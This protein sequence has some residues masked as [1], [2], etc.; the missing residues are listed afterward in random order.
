M[1]AEAS[2]APFGIIVST[3]TLKKNS[4]DVSSSPSKDGIDP[5]KQPP[6]TSSISLSF[7]TP[8]SCVVVCALENDRLFSLTL[9]FPVVV[10]VAASH[11]LTTRNVCCEK[12]STLTSIIDETKNRNNTSVAMVLIAVRDPEAMR[13]ENGNGLVLLG[14]LIFMVIAGRK[15]APLIKF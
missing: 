2:T 4:F 12:A 11:L 1:A 8:N 9:L 15:R 10:D 5:L 7:F 13:E 3:G 14:R 6:L